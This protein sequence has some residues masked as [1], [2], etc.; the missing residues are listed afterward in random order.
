MGGKEGG[1][2]RMFADQ[3]RFLREGGRKGG[4]EEGRGDTLTISG[5]M[6]PMPCFHLVGGLSN[7]L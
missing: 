2:E 7:V 6:K 1:K 4:R 5:V 3:V